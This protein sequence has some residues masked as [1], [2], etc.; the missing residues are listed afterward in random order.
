MA[1]RIFL[2]V[3][4]VSSFCLGENLPVKA[5]IIVGNLLVLEWSPSPTPEV[6]YVIYVLQGDSVLKVNGTTDTTY[7]FNLENWITGLTRVGFCVKAKKGEQ[8]SVS[9][10]T[11][12]YIFSPVK[13][14]LGD[15]NH[16]GKINGWDSLSF[17]T[18]FIKSKAGLGNTQV[19]DVNCD[20]KIDG[21]DHLY[22]R[23]NYGQE[24][25]Y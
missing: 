11:V 9:S 18:A 1:T 13:T 3:L 6:S 17:W 19:F 16:D 25:T 10:D 12:S 21:I 2:I 24:I 22:F 4:L 14:L 23:T 15:S 20:G 8:Y 7:S 5:P